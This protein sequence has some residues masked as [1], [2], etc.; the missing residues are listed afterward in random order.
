MPEITPIVSEG[1]ITVQAQTQM[2]SAQMRQ[3]QEAPPAQ[4]P[5]PQNP[6]QAPQNPQTPPP[7][8]PPE[9]PKS[10]SEAGENKAVKDEG[11]L[12][13][14]LAHEK[15]K[16]QIE[17]ERK[18]LDN[19]KRAIETERAQSR[20]WLEAEELAKQGK[21]LEAAQR[22]GISYEQMTQQILNNGQIPPAQL[23]QQTAAEL[24]EKK[25][26]E[27]QKRLEAQAK[28]SQREQY[29]QSLKQIAA[30]VKYVVDSSDKYELAKAYGSYN[31]IVKLIEQ[32]FHDTGRIIPVEAAIQKW[33]DDAL[34]GLQALAKLEKVRS[35]VFQ[36]SPMHQPVQQEQ[37]PNTLSQK[38]MAPVPAPRSQ[39][40]QERRQRAIDAF[41]G[42]L[43][44]R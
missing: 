16:R 14:R 38:A 31:D 42:K 30:E 12:K 1:T 41:Y 18:R 5:Q 13:A 34:E 11:V 6:S 15:L 35:R 43:G 23:A 25:F 39:T 10:G 37:V 32:T 26:E 9:P 27:Y 40:D 21:V 8:P 3:A 2:P 20:K 7:P 29:T 36:E 19:D 44:P 24:V 22:A 17:Q 4:S 33:E 28:A